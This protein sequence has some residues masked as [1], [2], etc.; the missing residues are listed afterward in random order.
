MYILMVP[1]EQEKYVSFV[2]EKK[3]KSLFSVT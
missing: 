1:S 3:G 2:G